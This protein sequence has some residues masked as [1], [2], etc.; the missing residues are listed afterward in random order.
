[1]VV[2]DFGDGGGGGLRRW[3]RRSTAMVGDRGTRRWSVIGVRGGARWRR[4]TAMGFS[5]ARASWMTMETWQL[6]GG[7]AG[8]LVIYAVLVT[9]LGTEVTP[10]DVGLAIVFG[11]IG[12]YLGNAVTNRLKSREE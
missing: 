1:M 11:A 2:V 7:L 5:W 9:A 12:L 4:S 8:M 3:W 10:F 6:R